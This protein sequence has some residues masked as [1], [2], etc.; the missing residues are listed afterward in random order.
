MDDKLPCIRSECVLQAIEKRLADSS[1][2]ILKRA[3]E[4]ISLVL[5][6]MGVSWSIVNVAVPLESYSSLYLT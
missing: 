3:V 6:H 2:E 5:P 1:L 4:Y